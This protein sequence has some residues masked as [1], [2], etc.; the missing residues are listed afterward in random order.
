[1]AAG[2]YAP[3]GVG[4]AYE[5]AGPRIYEVGRV[6][7]RA[8]YHT[9]NPYLYLLLPL[10]ADW[11]LTLCSRVTLNRQCMYWP[12]QPGYRFGELGTY[13]PAKREVPGSTRPAG[14]VSHF[15]N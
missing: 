12:C 9:I 1:M 7:L 2:L 13:S 14:A 5:R 8:R 11:R 10:L 3:R 15:Y 4:M 6:A